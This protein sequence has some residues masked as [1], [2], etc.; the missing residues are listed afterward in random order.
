[1]KIKVDK[2]DAESG[3]AY[4]LSTCISTSPR[5]RDCVQPQTRHGGEREA[6]LH[7]AGTYY[8]V[9]SGFRLL[10]KVSVHYSVAFTANP[11]CGPLALDVDN[12]DDPDPTEE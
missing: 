5:R 11:G 4:L 8:V 6:T 7:E 3:P 2:I 1:M 9:V 10:K 12:A